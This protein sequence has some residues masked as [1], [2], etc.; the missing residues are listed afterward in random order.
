MK[1]HVTDLIFH[2]LSSFRELDNFLFKTLKVVVQV[3]DVFLDPIEQTLIVR[4]TFL[5]T[6]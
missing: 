3:M 5:F 2:V 1:I 4:Y 6:I